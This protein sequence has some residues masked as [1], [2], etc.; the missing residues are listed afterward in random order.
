MVAVLG[1]RDVMIQKFL[2]GLID[3]MRQLLKLTAAYLNTPTSRMR[4]MLIIVTLLL[5]LLLLQWSV[6][7]ILLMELVRGS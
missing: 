3:F 1:I 4:F 6:E 7:L 2:D 5:L